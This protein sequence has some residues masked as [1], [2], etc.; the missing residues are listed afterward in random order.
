MA[1]FLV[2]RTL[3]FGVVGR[4]HASAVVTL[5]NIDLFLAARDLNVN[6][7]VLVPAVVV[8]VTMVAGGAKKS[9]KALHSGEKKRKA[10]VHV[11]V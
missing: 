9:E 5:C 6:L 4:V 1:I 8:S 10:C 2:T 3:E 11:E 7:G